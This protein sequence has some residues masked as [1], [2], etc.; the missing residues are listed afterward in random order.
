M[1]QFIQ[2]HVVPYDESHMGFHHSANARNPANPSHAAI[3]GVGNPSHSAINGIPL[4]YN[5]TGMYPPPWA[6]L[7]H[8]PPWAHSHI[9]YAPV[10]YSRIQYAPDSHSYGQ[11]ELRRAVNTD[12][13]NILNTGEG[14]RLYHMAV[15]KVEQGQ[16][17]NAAKIINECRKFLKEKRSVVQI[18]SEYTNNRQ[19]KTNFDTLYIGK[20]NELGDLDTSIIRHQMQEM[21][22]AGI[23][24]FLDDEEKLENM[25]QRI[26]ALE[27][28]LLYFII[29]CVLL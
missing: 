9:Q 3:H 24:K 14:N 13:D 25:A 5:S 20:M 29:V 26:S 1:Y 22:S 10:P 21:S 18:T 8:P 19:F 2:S 15:E 6:H 4:G 23:A 27:K 28:G 11:N 17:E 7:V 16:Y 12:L